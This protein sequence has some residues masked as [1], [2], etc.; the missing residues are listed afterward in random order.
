MKGKIIS[1]NIS[2]EKGVSKKPIK[3]NDYAILKENFGIVGDVHS[4]TEREVSF[5]GQETIEKWLKTKIKNQKIQIKP[6][7]FA[8][9]ITTKGINWEKVKCGDKIKVRDAVLI[10]TQIG[11]FCHSACNIRKLF[12]DCIMPKEGIFAKVIKGGKIKCGDK[13]TINIEGLL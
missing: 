13:I 12:G 8:E 10:I 3:K 9:N 6:G 7:S 1:I 2:K 11:K 4:G 5:L